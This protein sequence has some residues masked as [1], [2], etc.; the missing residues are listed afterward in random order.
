MILSSRPLRFLGA[1][2][3]GWVGV[4]TAMLWPVGQAIV[5][6]VAPAAAAEANPA[7]LVRPAAAKVAAARPA[8]LRQGTR[9]IPPARQAAGSVVALTPAGREMARTSPVLARSADLPLISPTNEQPLAGV[10]APV[11]FQASRWSVSAWAILRPDGRATPF[12]SQLGGSQAGAR[13]AY[14]IDG[15]RRIAVYARVS[16]AI[17]AR[18]REAAVGIDWRPTRLPIHLAAERRIGIEGIRSGTAI[19]AFGGMG[20]TRAIGS[21]QVEGYAQGGVIFRERPEGYADGSARATIPV[22]SRVDLG[23]GAWGGAQRGAARVDIGPTIGVTL[24]VARHA[25]R[26]SADWRQR[27]AGDARPGSGPALSLGTDF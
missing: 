14:A 2:I 27:V 21:V 3:G 5:Q 25:L 8:T 13:I 26:L 11:A 1:V 10:D 20:R 4:R 16:S 19:G 15:A 22:T 23:L 12:A 9:S 18:Q 6:A 17:D 24:P 7:A